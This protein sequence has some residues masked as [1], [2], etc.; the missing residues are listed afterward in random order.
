[1]SDVDVLS[2]LQTVRSM[3]NGGAAAAADDDAKC[4]LQTWHRDSQVLLHLAATPLSLH[5]Q[6]SFLGLASPRPSLTHMKAR[7]HTHTHID[8]DSP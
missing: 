3:R 1:V 5:H 2:R 8:I 7:A 6:L 4:Q